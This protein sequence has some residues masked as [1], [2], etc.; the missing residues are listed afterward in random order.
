M[1]DWITARLEEKFLMNEDLRDIQNLQDRIVRMNSD[2][3]EI[4]WETSAWE[5]VRSDSHQIAFRCT[6]DAVWIQGSPARIMGDGCNVFGFG[7][8]QSMDLAKCVKQMAL[9]VSNMIGIQ[10]PLEPEK[11]K[12]SRVDI[13]E[14]LMFE[15]LE[16]VRD[17]LR[18]LRNVEGGRYRVS[19][20]AGDTVYWSKNSKLKKGKAYAKGPH[21][22]YLNKKAN[23]SKHYSREEIERANRL[24]R[25]ELTL[26]SQ[27]WR[28]RCEKP[29]YELTPEDLRNY[30]N[31]YFMRMLGGQ[32][33]KND[34]EL[35]DNIYQAAPTDG[36][37][38]SAYGTWAIIKSEGWERAKEMHSK[39]TWYRNLKILRQA[40]LS[41]AELSNAQVLPF[42]QKIIEFQIVTSWN[43]LKLVA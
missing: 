16:Q 39:R 2:T 19:Q 15:T 40:G 4:V 22:Q 13:T 25:L 24:L 1:I 18:I 35:K 37:A 3:G 23:S 21:L 20:Q 33:V 5:S 7:A 38:K 34:T 27:F 10:L 9:F 28:E 14:N 30:W 29:Y 17:T 32:E 36:Q 43:E 12:V 6:G 26:A 41:D 8:S 42:K 11:W 31:E